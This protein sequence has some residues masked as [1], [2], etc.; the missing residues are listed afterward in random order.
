M[1]AEQVLVE[2]DGFDKFEAEDVS[3]DRA[4]LHYRQKAGE[5][6]H[7]LVELMGPSL[8]KPVAERFILRAPVTED[9]T[10]P[11]PASLNVT[12]LN[13]TSF[14]V[15]AQKVVADF[16][17]SEPGFIRIP[18]G[19][20]PWH[21]IRLDGAKAV[22]Y[23]DVMNMICVCVDT[24]GAHHLQVGPSISPAKRTGAWITGI[25]FL[26]FLGLLAL[27]EMRRREHRRSRGAQ[28]HRVSRGGSYRF[29]LHTSLL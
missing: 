25:S 18:F 27:A 24:A 16:T 2:V 19:W 10:S 5:Y 13:V 26:V 20:F 21:T 9:L 17:T 8:D 11:G 28:P 1:E 23:P 15:D 22:A 7:R 12:S 14:F 29:F 3:H 6:M 4:P